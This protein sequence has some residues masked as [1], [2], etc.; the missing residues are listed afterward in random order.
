[1]VN[2]IFKNGKELFLSRQST[3]LGAAV[4]LMATVATSRVL[5]LIRTRLLASYFSTTDTAVYL[6]AFRVPDLIYNLLIFGALSVAFIPVFSDILNREGK[7]KAN[8]FASTMLT[9]GVV[10]FTLVSLV[11]MIFARPLSMLVAIGFKPEEIDLMVGLSRLL[12]LSQV[13]FVIGGLFTSILQTYKYFFVPAIAGIL[14]NVGIIIGIVVF[15]PFFGLYGPVYGVL[16]GS[17]LYLLIHLPLIAKTG[18]VYQ[19]SFD[20][21]LPGVR[22]VFKLMLPRTFSI[23]GDQLRTTFN[24]S[25]ASII[26]TQSVTYLSFAQQLYLVPVG[27]FI[28]T[29]AQAA[30]PVLSEEKALKQYDSFAKTLVTSL[31]QVLFLTLPA[32]AILIVLRIPVVRLAFGAGQFDWEATVLTGKTVAWLALG[33][34]AEAISMLFIRAYYAMHDTM[35]PVKVTMVAILIDVF[36]SVIAIFVY[37]LP[38]WSLGISSTIGGTISA[39]LLF[40]TLNTR[41]GGRLLSTT[42]I[43]PFVRMTF[44]AVVMAISLYIPIKL[45]DQVVFDTTRTVNLIV[46]TGIA[47]SCGMIMYLILTWVF[48]VKEAFMVMNYLKVVVEKGKNIG[49]RTSSAETPNELVGK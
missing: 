5:G 41:L 25:V 18:F 45:L 20:W 22:R 35:T 38:V 6:A 26:S 31:H 8:K 14:Y 13:F 49:F 19:I 17:F 1:M 24:L 32:A 9:L 46:L 33:L 29:M 48:R 27:L 43:W 2:R 3:I 40:I 11:A 23:A 37:H 42:F 21:R 10:V 15:T 28:A 7:A 39:I 44:A 34:V 12:F 36:C 30:L 16:L 4:I 47:G